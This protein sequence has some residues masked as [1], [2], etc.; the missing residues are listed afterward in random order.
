MSYIISPPLNRVIEYDCY[1]R[2]DVSKP[3]EYMAESIKNHEQRVPIK[4]V[5]RIVEGKLFFM[6]LDGVIR[7]RAIKK[8]DWPDIKANVVTDEYCQQVT[9]AAFGIRD[10]SPIFLNQYYELHKGR[11]I[12]E[13][14]RILEVNIS[15]LEHLGVKL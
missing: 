15:L 2:G 7:Y 11:G 8:L 14:S 6:I 3:V 10:T 4:V 1:F 13:M 5:A 12:S 9:L